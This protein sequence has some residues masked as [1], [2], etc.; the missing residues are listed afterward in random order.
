M[1]CFP[2]KFT[3]SIVFYTSLYTSFVCVT[4]C[5]NT[6]NQHPST[7]PI[8]TLPAEAVT[9]QAIPPIVKPATPS[10]TAS[11]KPS[12]KHSITKDERG[13]K[14]GPKN[15][16]T[17][18]ID[19]GHGGKDP[20]AVVKGVKEKTIAL[21]VAKKLKQQLSGQFNVVMMRSGDTF[22]DLDDRVARSHPYDSALLI[23]IHANYSASSAVR[24]P[25]T[26]YFRVDSYG[27]SKRCQQAMERIS[28]VENRNAGLKRRRLRLTRNPRIP[29]LLIELGYLTNS[30]E[31]NLL[32]QESYRSKMA[33]ALANAI[34]T[35][36]SIGDKG[37]G[38][39][40]QP[41]NKPLSRPTDTTTL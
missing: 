17:V 28:P 7:P 15:F 12:K 38:T 6:P 3:A 24:G 19:A 41:L 8:P 9:Q 22:V 20:G 34:K 26:Y 29:C 11:T 10:I 37:M 25:E 30:T 1:K 32:T 33:T 35:Q 23:S 40:P 14:A 13:H 36:N 18:I 5:N 4:S 16:K 2:N 39:L 27:I 31:R 21:D